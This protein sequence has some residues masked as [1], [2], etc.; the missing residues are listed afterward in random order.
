MMFKPV[1][2]SVKKRTLIIAEM[3]EKCF[4][5]GKL[6]MN[7]TSQQAIKCKKDWPEAIKVK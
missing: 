7:H 3:H 4:V 1:K 5:C 2:I 6:K